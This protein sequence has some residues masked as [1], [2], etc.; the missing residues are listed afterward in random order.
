MLI[1]RSRS[2]ECLSAA[3]NPMAEDLVP[4]SLGPWE[5]G[6][7]QFLGS[8]RPE[9]LNAT[10]PL[11]RTLTTGPHSQNGDHA[12]RGGAKASAQADWKQKHCSDYTAGSGR[13]VERPIFCQ[14]PRSNGMRQGKKVPLANRKL[15]CQV[16]EA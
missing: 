2:A 14:E 15:G 1:P 5:Q 3:E 13:F 16:V 9:D 12:A 10:W 11:L 6:S 4:A 7:G 8:E